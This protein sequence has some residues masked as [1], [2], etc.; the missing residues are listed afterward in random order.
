MS[1]NNLSTANKRHHSSR[2][3]CGHI[4][5]G[6]YLTVREK[7]LMSLLVQLKTYK[8]TA[9]SMNLSDRTVEFY[10]NN[11]KMKFNCR[12]KRELISLFF[13]FREMFN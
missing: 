9:Q 6:A 10:T 2:T 3:D 12:T 13:D 1:I 5:Q 11:I 8:E 4:Y 7:E